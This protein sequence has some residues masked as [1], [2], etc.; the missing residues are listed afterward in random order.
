MYVQVHVGQ[1]H[2]SEFMW[3]TLSPFDDV[4]QLDHGERQPETISGAGRAL[5]RRSCL[6]AVRSEAQGCTAARPSSTQ[7]SAMHMAYDTSDSQSPVRSRYARVRCAVDVTKTP[8]GYAD[9]SR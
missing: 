6:V 3:T 5:D 8:T 2:A 9:Y 1:H 7:T 4:A